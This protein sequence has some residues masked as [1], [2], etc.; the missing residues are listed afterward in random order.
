M[1]ASQLNQPVR[2]GKGWS[3][4]LVFVPR[5]PNRTC[6]WCG[7]AFHAFASG[8]KRGQ[9]KY[10]SNSCRGA[11]VAGKIGPRIEVQ[12]KQCGVDVFVQPSRV[13]KFK[14]CSP[15]CGKQ[16][17]KLHYT[18]SRPRPKQNA[19]CST[20]GKPCPGYRKTCSPEC[21]TAARSGQRAYN[22]KG[23][24][25]TAACQ[26]CGR[27]FVVKPSCRGIACSSKCFGVVYATRCHGHAKGPRGKGGK[28]AD[29][30]GLYVRS[31]WEANWARYLN[32]LVA[33]GKV[34]RW[35][36]E[37]E[38]FLFQKRTVRPFSYTPDF[39][40]Y[41][42]DGTVLFHEIKGMSTPL[43]AAKRRAMRREHPHVR[44]KL[45]S[46]KGYTAIARQYS[47][48]IPE[49]ERSKKKAY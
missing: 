3:K 14:Y 19:P 30:G 31:R 6:Q 25:R 20:C 8:I 7:K 33:Q 46:I 23:G 39:K 44:V 27:L 2:K 29:L 34:T 36:Y 47:R 12:C 26:G 38:T 41:F 17:R 21:R 48:V 49:W 10:C 35:E 13:K 18:N 1:A 24:K 9:Y 5:T 4:G 43:D 16:Y 32:L 45:V 11:S 42:A 40:V 22:W 15:E 28:R 37:P